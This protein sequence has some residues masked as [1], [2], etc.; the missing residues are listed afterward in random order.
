LSWKDI[1]ENPAHNLEEYSEYAKAP[2]GFL[3]SR[4]HRKVADAEVNTLTVD[5]VH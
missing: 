3:P 5:F 4:R 1:L 2:K